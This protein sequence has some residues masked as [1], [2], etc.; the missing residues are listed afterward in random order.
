[1]AE[2]SVRI[3]LCQVRA[4]LGA[5]LLAAGTACAAN[6]SVAPSRPLPAASSAAAA[7]WCDRISARLPTVS[8]STCR[9]SAV[10]PSGAKSNNGFP[11]LERDIGAS[12]GS[13][14]PRVLLLGGIHGDELTASALVFRWLQTIDT[15]AAQGL[16]W[17]V[18]PLLNPDG[19]LAAKPQ[20][21]NAHGV[22]LNR[23]FPTPDWQR[24]APR[25]WAKVTRSDPRRFPGKSPLSEPESRWVHQTIE[26]FHPDLVVSVH[27]PF[28]V[29][30]FDG[31]AEPPRKFGRLNYRKVGVYPGSLGNYSGQHKQVPVITIE[32]P[33]AQAMPSDAE[34][35][36][37]WLDMLEWIR[38]NLN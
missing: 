25:Y 10:V 14:A 4:G 20:R 30:D 18:V 16:N 12:A 17:K 35:Q 13:T 22:D 7:P 37:I 31:D 8:A 23:N 38:T 11:I 34:I 32:L 29:L 5:W 19:L 24:E 21:V 27:A 26:N 3:S 15:P 36:R 9:Q 33:H 6:A 2:E 28:G 1:M